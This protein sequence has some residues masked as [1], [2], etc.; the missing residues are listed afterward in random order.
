MFTVFVFY[1]PPSNNNNNNRRRRKTVHAIKVGILDREHGLLKKRKP[2]LVALVEEPGGRLLRWHKTASPDSPIEMDVPLKSIVA[3]GRLVESDNNTYFVV[4]SDSGNFTFIAPTID[5]LQT[6]VKLLSPQA[7]SRQSST[8]DDDRVCGLLSV[9]KKKDR[10]CVLRKASIVMFKAKGDKD[11]VGAIVLDSLCT[12]KPPETSEKLSARRATVS[13]YTFNIYT[14]SRD[15]ALKAK[16]MNDANRWVTA[17]Q[18]AI[19][20]CPS[21]TTP[22]SKLANRHAG[23]D[24]FE[25]EEVIADRVLLC[26]SDEGLDMPLTPLPYGSIGKRPSGNEYGFHHIEAMHIYNSLLPGQSSRFG[27]LSDVHKLA[28]NLFLVC[29]D[30]PMLR[31]EIFMQILKQTTRHPRP[32]SPEH[33]VYWFL[34]AALC[35]HHVPSG[36]QDKFLRSMLRMTAAHSEYPSSVKK[37]ANFCLEALSG[38]KSPVFH[39]ALM[40]DILDGSAFDRQADGLV[41]DREITL[42][43]DSAC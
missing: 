16:T 6:W 35:S 5:D 39:D 24:A 38:A 21:L 13:G 32:G 8:S 25:L 33:M 15:W 2:H 11:P 12:V 18:D 36:A 31:N 28:R 4:S 26:F 19:E 29:Q 41:L 23:A 14:A 17:L 43:D 37:A 42:A 30:V 34:L 22:F 3:V 27:D 1:F 40:K 7:L 10:W 9:D 20:A